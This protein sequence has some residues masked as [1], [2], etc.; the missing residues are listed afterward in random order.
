MKPDKVDEVPESKSQQSGDH[1][2][3][4]GPSVE[5]NTKTNAYDPFMYKNNGKNLIFKRT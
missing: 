1:D 2:N 4:S 3:I 5:E